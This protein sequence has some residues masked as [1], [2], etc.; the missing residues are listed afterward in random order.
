[1]LPLPAKGEWTT[2][3]SA[4]STAPFCVG[5]GTQVPANASDGDLAT[6]WSSGVAQFGDEWVQVDFG[7]SVTLSE[8]VLDSFDPALVCGGPE[9]YPRYFQARLSN[10]SLDFSAPVLA[11]GA[12]TLDVTTI[13]FAAP[14]AGRYLLIAQTGMT[15][16]S[17]WSIAEIDVACE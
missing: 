10:A 9:D 8:V 4:S 6:R 5:Q 3:A 13:E 11:E 1:V 2:S 7:A 15:S 16:P 12:G 17:W 14:A